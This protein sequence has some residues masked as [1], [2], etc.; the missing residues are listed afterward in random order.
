LNSVSGTSI[1][2]DFYPI[3]GAAMSQYK[4][5]RLN[6]ISVSAILPRENQKSVKLESE[7]CI[8][9]WSKKLGRT[10]SLFTSLEISF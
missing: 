7:S 10:S 4:T 9:S 2:K 3:D 1:R 8:L 5:P 6:L